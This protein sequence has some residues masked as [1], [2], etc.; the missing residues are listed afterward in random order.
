ME[1]SPK[2]FVIAGPNGAGKS[3]GAAT[4]LPNH[5]P[6]DK[7]LNADNIAKAIATDSPLEAGRVM[8][9]RMRDLR[10]QRESF[11]F[12]TTLS[13]KCHARFLKRA[14]TEGY[15][16]HLAYI[17]LSSVEL[18]SKRVA[19]RVRRGGHGIPLADIKRRYSRGLRNLFR[20][21]IPLA[22]RWVVCDNS[23][24]S[25]VPVARGRRN[26]VSAVYDKAVFDRISYESSK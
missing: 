25:L 10:D 23:G 21:Y 9:R 1:S 17:W 2:I 5:F 26:D 12:E 6:T 7:F 8:L 11:A 19:V 14:Q 16:V 13:G 4:I 24:S 18:A 22:N 15:I 3:T 20:L